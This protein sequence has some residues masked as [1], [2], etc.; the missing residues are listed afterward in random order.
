MIF[1]NIDEAMTRRQPV[2]IS[3]EHSKVILP[4]YIP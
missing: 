1:G 2:I 3:L 4:D